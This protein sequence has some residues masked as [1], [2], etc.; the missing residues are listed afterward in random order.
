MLKFLSK[1]S[2][3]AQEVDQE[4][5][6][7]DHTGLRFEPVKGLYLYAEARFF[8]L[9]FLFVLFY[10]IAGETGSEWIYLIAAGT[11][12]LIVL[13]LTL[14]LFQILD[15]HASLFFPGEAAAQERLPI[16]LVVTHAI[17]Q[18]VL[19][20]FLPLR[21]IRFKTNLVKLDKR[22]S[23]GFV[24]PCVVVHAGKKE[25]VLTMTEPLKRGLYRFDSLDASTCF[26]FAILWW[27]RKLPVALLQKSLMRDA[28]LLT[29][30][31]KLVPMRSHFLK[32][33][34]AGGDTMGALQERNRAS[35]ES[36]AVRGLRE[37][38]VGDS[39]R[40]VHW[41]STAR[42]NRLLVK[43]FESESSPQ[44]YVALDTH[45]P[46]QSEDQFELAVC[47]AY[48]ILHWQAPRNRF[49]LLV[50]PSDELRDVYAMPSGLARSREI[51]ARLQQQLIDNTVL[52]ATDEN[53]E[54]SSFRRI[55]EIF[56]ETLRS[57]PG[58]I[59]FTIFPGAGAS[60]V[61]LIETT[62]DKHG[63]PFKGVGR[64]QRHHALSPELVTGQHKPLPLKDYAGPARGQMVARISQIEQIALL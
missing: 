54:E 64:P 52:E 13:G 23:R 46:W 55:E 41:P 61:N 7:R 38:R 31:P 57:H 1:K 63:R 10:L 45:A 37:Y 5:V 42:T 25:F 15:T 26:P 6:E 4:I 30:Y 59:L 3:P 22:S 27:S 43:E 12:A 53:P 40:W 32:T 49:E 19:A 48:S 56:K 44:Y 34:G 24:E 58:S 9:L 51:L 35:Q 62:L 36:S 29:V 2:A 17:F 28:G 39:P 50:P 18:G 21:W 16:Q 33:L 14:P 47:L 11:F 8:I 20:D 60:V